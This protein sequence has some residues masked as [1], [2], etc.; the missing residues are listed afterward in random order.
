MDRTELE[1]KLVLRLACHGLSQPLI[2][3]TGN[4]R[5]P[6]TASRIQRN[7]PVIRSR[8]SRSLWQR[9]R[10][11][12][13]ELRHR[14]TKLQPCEVLADRGQCRPASWRALFPL[15]A[16]RRTIALKRREIGR[17]SADPCSR[18]RLTVDVFSHPVRR[19]PSSLRKRTW[20]NH[21]GGA[22][23]APR[24]SPVAPTRASS[25]KVGGGGQARVPWAGGCSSQTGSRGENSSIHT[26]GV[27]ALPRGRPELTAVGERRER[28]HLDA[29]PGAAQA[30]AWVSR[31]GAAW[32]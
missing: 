28:E 20:A 7:W 17:T 26:S 24:S 23:R 13:L 25:S 22:D 12:V 3:R 15:P 1:L 8:A 32:L 14:Q 9:L 18:Y 16:R 19:R 6:F 5:F 27:P 11:S 10:S 29:A 2:Q 4:T 31:S 30:E 21:R